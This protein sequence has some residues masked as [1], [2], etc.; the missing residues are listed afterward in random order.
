MN[1][2]QSTDS[3]WLLKDLKATMMLG[4]VLNDIVP[5]LKLLLLEGPLGAGKTSLVKGIGLSLGIDEPIT[6][7]TFALAQHYQSGKSPLFH[8]DLYRLE[9]H[10]DADNL[11][12]Q[13]EE[14]ALSLGALL[15]VEWPERLNVSL[16]DAWT[17]KLKYENENQR[18]AQLIPPV[19]SSRKELT[20]WEVG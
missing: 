8:L 13:E 12:I 20:S 18:F 9:D 10:K 2:W 6:S 15:V 19:D 1:Q 11:F 17:M 16:T 7:P 3:C 5:N 14:E 4:T